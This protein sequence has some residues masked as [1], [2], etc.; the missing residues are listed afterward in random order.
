MCDVFSDLNMSQLLLYLDDILVFASST[1]EHLER[2]GEVFH[3]LIQAGLKLNT[4]TCHLFRDELSTYLG[5][6][7]SGQGVSVDPGKVNKVLQWPVPS[8]RGELASFLGLASYYRRFVPG[9][10]TV[11]A[12]LNALRSPKPRGWVNL[13]A[14]IGLLKLSVHF[15]H[16]RRL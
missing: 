13:W 2:L 9:F 14:P 4:K 7:V 6:I 11:A 15:V 16:L 5:Q 10:A 3:R 1:E 8:T 12:P